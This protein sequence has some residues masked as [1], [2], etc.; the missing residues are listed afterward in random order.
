MAAVGYGQWDIVNMLIRHKVDLFKANSKGKTISDYLRPND[1]RVMEAKRLMGHQEPDRP[2]K[3]KPAKM[4]EH[5]IDPDSIVI[6][7]KV[8]GGNFGEVY[9]GTWEDHPVALKRLTD[10]NQEQDFFKEV[11]AIKNISQHP[12]IVRFF[13]VTMVDG[14][15][16]LVTEFCDGGSLA[17]YLRTWEFSEKEAVAMALGIAKGVAALHRK[18]VVHRDLAARN[19]LVSR[20]R[21]GPVMKVGDFGMSRKMQDT[22]YYTKTGIVLP[23]RWSAPEALSNGKF[24][25]FS[26]VWS[27]GITLWEIYE[28]GKL[29]YAELTDV[30]MKIMNGTR[31]ERP[32]LCTDDQ[33][34][35][36]IQNCWKS[37][38]NKR[39]TMDAIVED[40]K[41]IYKEMP[42]VVDNNNDEHFPVLELDKDGY[43]IS[44]EPQR[45]P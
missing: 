19:V 17:E 5:E 25:K 21:T 31:L 1:A 18:K 16:N 4:L 40:L 37:P 7:R 33:I 14:E 29:P 23:I 34:W 27:F 15:L 38:A 35:N 43:S 24:T 12:N 45:K 26:D 28:Q 39:P 32:A 20:E 22:D 3:G 11:D 8:G 2:P 13:G 42:D 10:E 44:P 9:E 30:G 36:I 41:R 6:L